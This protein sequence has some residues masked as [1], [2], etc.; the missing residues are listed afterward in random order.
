MM[1]LYNFQSDLKSS[2]E[3]IHVMWAFQRAYKWTPD[4]FVGRTSLSLDLSG[5]FNPDVFKFFSTHEARRGAAVI[6]GDDFFLISH[7]I[8]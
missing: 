6:C 8:Q 3:V 2:Q 7:R 4:S 5:G 1:Q